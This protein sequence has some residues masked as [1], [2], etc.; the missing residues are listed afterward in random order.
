MPT[1]VQGVYPG[2]MNVRYFQ[3][4]LDS[5]LN[6]HETSTHSGNQPEDAYAEKGP[7]SGHEV[8][9]SDPTD[10]HATGGILSG[11]VKP[12]DP[13]ANDSVEGA[14]GVIESTELAPLGE[15][16]IAAD[17]EPFNTVKS[18]EGC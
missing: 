18:R 12:S 5:S 7:M 10:P 17:R 2:V 6:P 13:K 3:L 14:P 16:K 11:H 9:S 15:E 8:S 1:H 4:L